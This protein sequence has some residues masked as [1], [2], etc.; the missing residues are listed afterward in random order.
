MTTGT[1]LDF[2]MFEHPDAL[3]Q[4]LI[5]SF[6]QNA[7]QYDLRRIKQHINI[8]ER[9]LELSPTAAVEVLLT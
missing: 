7:S 5:Y 4:T 6:Y 9:I 8:M 1:E 2:E 3:K